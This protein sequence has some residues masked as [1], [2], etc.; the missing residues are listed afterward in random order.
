MQTRPQ[1]IHPVEFITFTNTCQHN[2]SINRNEDS[3][4]ISTELILGDDSKCHW[5]FNDERSY[6]ALG[7]I[8]FDEAPRSRF[9]S[10]DTNYVDDM[11][12]FNMLSSFSH[13][14]CN[15]DNASLI[16]DLKSNN[17]PSSRSDTRTESTRLLG[18]LCHNLYP[19]YIN[20]SVPAVKCTDEYL[21]CSRNMPHHISC[22]STSELSTAASSILSS[23][24]QHSSY[25]TKWVQETK[26][27]LSSTEPQYY[28][29]KRP[30]LRRSI[31]HSTNTGTPYNSDHSPVCSKLSSS[32][33][34][35]N[36]RVVP[37]I[38]NMMV[39][40]GEIICFNIILYMVYLYFMFYKYSLSIA[41]QGSTTIFSNE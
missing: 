15:S 35:H 3:S 16:P 21:R 5:D 14:C 1:I 38:Q 8:S 7:L 11:K 10:I 33:C 20:S 26:T 13:I 12:T 6:Y 22:N 40:A 19:E 32:R 18:R 17:E 28:G 27:R 24:S 23:L 34:N 41:I 2:D 39:A 9:H 36:Y 30:S 31:V 25:S 37:M 4:V 29:Q